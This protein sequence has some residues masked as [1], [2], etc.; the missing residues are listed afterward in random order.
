MIRSRTRTENSE[1][2]EMKMS[3]KVELIIQLLEQCK[4]DVLW[5]EER[6]KDAERE[7]NNIRHEMEGLGSERG[8]PPKFERRAVLATKW[9]HTLFMRRAA[10]DNISI[11]RPLS[12]FLD[13]DIG[14]HS[15]NHLKQVLGQTRNVEKSMTNRVY[16]NRRTDMAKNNPDL[17]KNLNKL[18]RRWKA[19]LKSKH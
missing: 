10:K 17:E 11:N 9:Q 6:F 4:S 14:K 8:K 18:I 13:S 15:L 16:Y 19:D 12:D 5:Y 3:E 1:T 2:F 7:E